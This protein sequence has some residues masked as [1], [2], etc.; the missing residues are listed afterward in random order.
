MAAPLTPQ[1]R[2]ALDS[3]AEFAARGWSPIALRGKRPLARGWPETGS[4]DWAN[5][6]VE[7]A[8]NVGLCTGQ[9]GGFVA[10]DVDVKDGGMDLWRELV[11]AHGTPRTVTVRT[12]SGGLHF[13]FAVDERTAT[14]SKSIKCVRHA[15]GERAGIDLIAAGGQVVAPPSIHPNRRRYAYIVPPADYPTLP[16]MPDWLFELLRRE[17]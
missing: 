15:S 8:E 3:A 1:Q 2:L 14:L 16:P 13:Y 9:L 7:G 6:W 5:R 12:G 10:V 11:A 17:Q 4:D